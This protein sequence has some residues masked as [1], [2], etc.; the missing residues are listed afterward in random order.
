MGRGHDDYEPAT[1]P[2]VRLGGADTDPGMEP[3]T[4]LDLPAY[5]GLEGP[6]T[7]PSVSVPVDQE[8][9][10]PEPPT[11][12]SRR[13]GTSIPAPAPQEDGARRRRLRIPWEMTFVVAAYLLFAA[14]VWYW[15][16]YQ[17]E[18]ARIARALAAGEAVMGQDQGRSARTEALLEAAD[19]YLEALAID[20][21][22]ATAHARLESIKW[23]LEER[24]ERVPTDLQLRHA[25]LAAR[26]R[27]GQPRIARL[28]VSA[29][30]RFGLKEK[31]AYVGEVLRWL[32]L[33]FIAILILALVRAF[34]P[35]AE[36][37]PKPPLDDRG[38]AAY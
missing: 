16:A 30:E 18:P 14:G 34:S 29:E 12:V 37:P 20:P 21:N 22:L 35:T 1:D 3:P 27:F 25:A 7:D 26:S 5:G 15:A 31:A 28:P 2:E 13:E 10:A 24:G 38:S 32:G 9:E 23:R 11:L 19:H 8:E 33:G 17:S 4:D 6:D 36:P